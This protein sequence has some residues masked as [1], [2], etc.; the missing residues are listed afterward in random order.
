MARRRLTRRRLTRAALLEAIARRM[1][2]DPQGYDDMLRLD[3]GV[4]V[5]KRGLVT[6]RIFEAL[7][8]M[9]RRRHGGGSVQAALGQGRP[10][11]HVSAKA[12]VCSI[13]KEPKPEADRAG[14]RHQRCRPCLSAQRLAYHHA[15]K[16]DQMRRLTAWRKRRKL[17]V[18]NG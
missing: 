12:F 7:N 13:C 5:H 6:P 1:R 2:V 10:P 15:N 4:V 8:S 16:A 17:L 18:G 14:G 11:T 3:L 9:G